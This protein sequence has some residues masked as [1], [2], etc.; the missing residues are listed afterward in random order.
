VLVAI[1]TV[2]LAVQLVGIDTPPDEPVA[3]DL[4]LVR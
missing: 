2:F 1:C 3:V 4:P